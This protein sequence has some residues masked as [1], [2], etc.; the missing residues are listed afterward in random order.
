MSKE[1][2]VIGD[3]HGN[4]GHLRQLVTE[5]P[6]KGVPVVLTGDVC[7]RGHFTKEVIQYLIDREWLCV[8]GNHDQWLKRAALTGVVDRN[9]L[10]PNNGGRETLASY[11]TESGDV[12]IPSE[13]GKWLAHLPLALKFPNVKVDGRSVVVTH[14]PL[15]YDAEKLDCGSPWNAHHMPWMYDAPWQKENLFGVC[16]HMMYPEPV[17]KGNTFYVD[18]GCGA[19]GALSAVK[20]PELEVFSVGVNSEV[21]E[22]IGQICQN[23]PEIPHPK[24]RR[25]DAAV[26]FAQLPVEGNF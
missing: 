19:G 23:Y 9:W 18:T 15:D 13:H 24:Q 2:V 8:L 22:A 1:L 12:L 17:R 10:I 6:W 21:R 26:A 7:D 4:I 16:G 11:R 14:A 20:L 5:M 3:V 25:E